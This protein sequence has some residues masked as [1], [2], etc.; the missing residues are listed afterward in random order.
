MVIIVT[1]QSRTSVRAGEESALLLGKLGNVKQVRLAINNFDIDAARSGARA[2]ILE[3]IDNCAVRC[4]GVVPKDIYISE[5][6]DMGLL[7][8]IK[9]PVYRSCKNIAA[10]IEGIETP[11]FT[12]MK[13][14][15]KK[16]IL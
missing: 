16:A 6:Q 3:L 1:E 10:R 12:G 7:P 2:G 9:S 13:K 5:I 4:I 11:L 15:R 14:E 8:D